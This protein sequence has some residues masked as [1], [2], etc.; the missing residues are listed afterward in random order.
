MNILNFPAQD[1]VQ[2]FIILD[3]E[4]RNDDRLYHRYRTTDP[5]PA[6]CRWPFRRVVS[7]TVMEVAVEHG[8]WEIT[9]FQSWAGPEDHQIVRQLFN[10]MIERPAH[11]LVTYAGASEDIPV[12]KTAAMEIGL[13][14]PRQLRHL[15]RDRAGWLH[16][17]LALVLK[18]GAGPYVHQLELATRL[19]L[20]AKMAGSAGQV[21]HLFDEGRFEAVAW[22]SE[23]DVLLTSL[24]LAAHL[25]SLGQVISVTAAQY[26][27][28]RFVRERRPTA[29]YHREL[30]NYL[31]KVARQM[32]EDQQGWLEAS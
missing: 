20:P 24:L 15:E 16:A 2:R 27:T 6:P 22:I 18:G 23:C 4:T 28:M 29:S 26:V 25:A 13:A 3:L 1:G 11:R 30:G 9:H 21:P 19:G 7:A 12:L 32:M 5:R 17:D 31:A 14:L 8:I 10:W